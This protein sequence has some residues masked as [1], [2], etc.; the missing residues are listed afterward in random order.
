M[1]GEFPQCYAFRGR[2]EMIVSVT[3]N[4]RILWNRNFSLL[5][6]VLWAIPPSFTSGVHTPLPFRYF[7]RTF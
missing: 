1:G 5:G 6:Q 2:V 4:S 7:R 3:T